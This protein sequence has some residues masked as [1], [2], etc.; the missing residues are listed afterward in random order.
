MQ[1]R[2]L[3][4]EDGA[5][6]AELEAAALKPHQRERTNPAAIAFFARSGHSFVAE[7]AGTPLGFV[8]AQ[9]LWQGDRATVLAT[10]LV[11][12]T[13]E[14]K[15]ALLAALTKSAY[16]A[17]AYEVAVV[18]DETEEAAL[19]QAGFVA[20]PRLFVRALGSRGARGEHRGVLE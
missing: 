1:V 5:R 19:K 20:G 4:Q 9:P 10:R 13:P 2:P 15:E 11:A 7:E 6:L 16:D 3:T 8:L 18:G 12:K 14:V 17:G